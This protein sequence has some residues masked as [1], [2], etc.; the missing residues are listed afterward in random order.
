MLIHLPNRLI[1]WPI[2]V[3]LV[4]VLTACRS[5][6]ETPVLNE[7]ETQNDPVPTLKTSSNGGSAI[8]NEP[9]KSYQQMIFLDETILEYAL[10]LPDNFSA[11]QT[12]PILLALPPGDQ[13]EAMV[14]AGLNY[15]EAEAIRRGWIVVSPI[16]P[17][18]T[19]FFRG[20]ES[21][22]PEFLNR[23]AAQFPPEGGKFHVAGVSNGGVSSFR[24]AINSP[25]LVQ[26]VVVL[27][28]YPLDGF[29]QDNLAN[30]KEIPIAMFVGEN[31]GAW[32]TRMQTAE[33]NLQE[34]GA[35]V[36]L[37]I[38]PGEGHVIRSINGEQLYDLLDSFR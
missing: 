6:P 14:E 33:Q 13:T 21:Y 38:R 3:I 4:L 1:L 8:V 22:I 26:S 9:G 29:D 18:F 11:D 31:D 12:Y 16:A 25:D 5:E 19:L 34:I 7:G 23:I 28:G 24:I 27:P 30:L 17:N 32:V 2:V 20:S 36:T 15:W 35:T 37:D 10:V